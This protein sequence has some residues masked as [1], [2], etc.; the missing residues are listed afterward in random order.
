MHFISGKT[1]LQQN[2]PLP[3]G[4]SPHGTLVFPRLLV[5]PG[6][7]LVP[8][9]SEQVSRTLWECEEL[10]KPAGPAGQEP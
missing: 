6:G 3:D 2:P 1:A 7:C 4:D 8:L 9:F 5:L 10:G